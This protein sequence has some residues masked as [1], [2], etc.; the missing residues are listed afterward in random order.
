MSGVE[1]SNSGS[2]FLTEQCDRCWVARAKRHLVKGE[3]EL[4][5]CEHHYTKHAP[6]LLEQGFDDVTSI[7][8]A[9]ARLGVDKTPAV[10]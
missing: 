4:Y 3:L 8:N 9:R 5:L 2:V 1:E 7:E 6:A 10:V